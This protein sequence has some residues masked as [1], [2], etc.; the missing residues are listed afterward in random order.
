MT[1]TIEPPP[2]QT[3][4]AGV[5]EEARARQRRHRG[6]TA[7]VLLAAAGITA[8]LLAFT[9]G[10]GGSHP[11]GAPVPA[12]HH[13]PKAARFSPAACAST[14]RKALQGTPNKSLLSIL[15]VLRR[16]PTQTDALPPRL[17]RL[18]AGSGAFDHYIRRARVVEGSSY[19]IYPVIL[20][21]CGDQARQA[22]E[23][24]GTNIDLGGGFI[25]S[26][27]GSIATV[28]DIEHDRA[29]TTDPP[30]SGTSSTLEMIVPDGVA[31][32]TLHY[33]V[34]RASGYSSKIS[35]SVTVTAFAFNNEVIATVPRRAAGSTIQRVTVIWQAAN[36]HI[37][38]TFD[39]F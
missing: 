25:G 14:T 4:D 32:V 10:G 15:G 9:G 30:G 36:G 37:I 31:K 18:G 27:A 6:V 38:K 17:K 39:T 16:P 11:Q 29:V 23:N 26:T 2:V 21:G 34:S 22:V 20:R 8:I 7:T 33:P 13:P 5:I 3:P 19:Y 12:G 35:R 24:P 1:I 28:A